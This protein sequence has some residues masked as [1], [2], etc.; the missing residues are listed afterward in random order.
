MASQLLL[1]AASERSS[2]FVACWSG[3]FITK[4]IITIPVVKSPLDW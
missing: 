4:K 3:R 2:F 1:S